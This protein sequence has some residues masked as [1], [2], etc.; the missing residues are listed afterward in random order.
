MTAT[1][2]MTTTLKAVHDAPQRAPWVYWP[3][4]LGVLAFAGVMLYRDPVSWKVWCGVGLFGCALVPGTLPFVAKQVAPLLALWKA[5][6]GTGGD[7][8]G[9]S[10]TP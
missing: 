2:R 1:Q 9:T 8:S 4:G 10:G 6:N 5:K 3:M 7:S